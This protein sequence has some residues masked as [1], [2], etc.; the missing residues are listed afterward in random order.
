MSDL[1]ENIDCVIFDFGEVLI[2]LD[3]PRII[4][5]FSLVAKRNEEEISELVVTAPLL[6]EL[7]IGKITPEEFRDGVN[8]LLG[9]SLNEHDFNI[10]WN[11]ML[12]NLPKERMDILEKVNATFD[13]R[14]LSNSNVIHEEAFNK[15][16]EEV[17]G[18]SSLHELVNKCYFSQDIGL[19]KPYRNCFEYVIND[20]G[21][22][23]GKILFL[24]DRADNIA[25]ASE[26][27]MKTFLVSDAETQLKELFN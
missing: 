21:I 16:I 19:R 22:D 14:I 10:I 18:K 11:S 15:M 26:T 25:G 7:E 24:D 1:L 20:I 5:G 4:A 17:T 13:T 27:G 9:I 8:K 3:Y 12:K 6:Q 2:E 23:P